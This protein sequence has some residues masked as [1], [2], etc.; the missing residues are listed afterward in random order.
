MKNKHA[1]FMAV[2]AA[3]LFSLYFRS[4]GYDLI[5]DDKIYFRGN[6]LLDQNRPLTE[7]FKVGYF[8]EQV[9]MKGI[10]HYYRPLLTASFMAEDRLW[11]ISPA[12]LRIVNILLYLGALFVFYSYFRLRFDH[13]Y[14]PEIATLLFALHPLNMD[15]VIWIVGRGDLLVLLWGGLVLL[16]FERFLQKGKPLDWVLAGLFFLFGVFSK[17]SFIFFWP[18]LIL[19]EGL[20]KRKITIPFHCA[21]LLSIVAFYAVKVGL[22][23]IKNIGL[24]FESGVISGLISALGTLGFY[25][26]SI[27]WP[28]TTP[29]FLSLNNAQKTGYLIIGIVSIAL[30]LLLLYASRKEPETRFPLFLAAIFIGGHLPLIFSQIFPYS[31]Y[32]RYMTIPALGLVWVLAVYLTKLPERTRI[33][34][35]FLIVLAFIP[36]IVIRAEANKTEEVFWSR[37]SRRSPND[38][39][40]LFYLSSILQQKGDF[41]QSELYLNRSLSLTLRTETVVF[42][43]LGYAEVEMAKADYD[44]VFKWLAKV[45]SLPKLRLPGGIRYEIARIKARAWICRGNTA[46]AENLLEQNIQAYPQAMD[47]YYDLFEMYTGF[48]MWEKASALAGRIRLLSPSFNQ[49]PDKIARELETMALDDKIAFYIFRRNFSKAESLVNTIRPLDVPNRILLGKL[50]YWRGEA[51]R[52][53]TIIEAMAAENSGNFGTMNSIAA[54]YLRDLFRVREALPY[55]KKSLELNPGQP[56]IQNLIDSLTKNYLD[57]LIEVWKPVDEIHGK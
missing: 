16:F 11:G 55:L 14:F 49:D 10:D 57:R 13:G 3:I 34:I 26:K 1:I 42:V 5:W 38:G 17:E 50:A 32:P 48:E 23:G 44:D 8:S 40:A 53:R 18:A 43:S 46:E 36:T 24:V 21:N 4:L 35:V 2:L 28:F 25:A 56:Q 54:F 22:L 29:F 39:Y 47:S 41:L 9:G 51:D 30:F 6:V 20:R 45:E 15:N 7:A 33:S 31:I 19:Y 12:G 37:A 27:V 52:G